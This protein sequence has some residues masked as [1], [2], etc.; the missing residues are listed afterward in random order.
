MIYLTWSAIAST[1][2]LRLAVRAELIAV[3]GPDYTINPI[4]I[5]V[6]LSLLLSLS[7]Q[8]IY[9]QLRHLLALAMM[10]S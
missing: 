7:L 5:K 8:P 4:G 9:F 2:V 6:R 10:S 3:L 1:T